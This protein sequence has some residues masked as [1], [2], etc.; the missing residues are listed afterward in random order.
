MTI[1]Y[2]FIRNFNDTFCINLFFF[3]TTPMSHIL[4]FS[5]KTFYILPMLTSKLKK[6]Y[7]FFVYKFKIDTVFA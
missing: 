6:S 3:T 2:S 1:Y 7:N 5:K 4:L